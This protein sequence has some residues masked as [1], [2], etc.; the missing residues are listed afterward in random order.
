VW[1]ISLYWSI[2]S[3]LQNLGSQICTQCSFWILQ[4]LAISNLL[5]RRLMHSRHL[6]QTW[7]TARY[8]TVTCYRQHCAQ[9]IMP[10]FK[11]L[12]GWFWGL[13]PLH[14]DKIN[15]SRWNSVHKCRW[16]VYASIPNMA[17]IGK[18]GWIQELPKCNSTK[19]CFH[20]WK[21]IQLNSFKLNLTCKHG[22]LAYYR[23][24]NLAQIGLGNLH[25]LPVL[26]RLGSAYGF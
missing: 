4:I 17:P 1:F 12:R 9:Q 19:L 15:Q 2:Q 22:P 24:P 18:G 21:V 25:M 10:V 14:C 23:M 6:C 13:S 5:M 16:W 20:P 7:T 3:Q 8:S 26:Q 11:F